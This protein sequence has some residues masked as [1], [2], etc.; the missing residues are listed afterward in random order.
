MFLKLDVEASNKNTAVDKVWFC[1]YFYVARKPEL[2]VVYVPQL[3]SNGMQCKGCSNL[4]D[5]LLQNKVHCNE[6]SLLESQS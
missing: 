4:L 2:T 6:D 3:G 5:N 1:Y